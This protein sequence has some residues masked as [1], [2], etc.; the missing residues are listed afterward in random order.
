ML[1]VVSFVIYRWPI[2]TGAYL[3][4]RSDLDYISINLIY[5]DLGV[6]PGQQSFGLVMQ[7]YVLANFYLVYRSSVPTFFD[8]GRLHFKFFAIGGI[9][10][11]HHGL[12]TIVF[13]EQGI[14]NGNST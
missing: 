14:L 10:Y 9:G 3:G 1:L 4:Q 5:I 11:V 6:F 2:S 12:I 7:Y 13:F 8:D